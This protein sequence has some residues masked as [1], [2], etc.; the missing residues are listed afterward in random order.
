MH[1]RIYLLVFCIC[2]LCHAFGQEDYT[3]DLA[4]FKAQEATYQQWLEDAGLGEVLKV[5]EVEVEPDLIS[6]YL[7]FNYT[8]LDSIYNAWNQLKASFDQRHDISL[9]QQL[10]YKFT[11]IFDLPEDDG[12]VQLYD[13]YSLDKKIC[14]YWGIYFETGEVITEFEDH[15]GKATKIFQVDTAD[16]SDTKKITAESIQNRLTQS[17]VFDE[18]LRFARQRFEQPVCPDRNP[19]V[20]LRENKHLLRFE[21]DDLCKEVLHD[22]SNHVLCRIATRLRFTCNTIS[23][24]RLNFTITY[25]KINKGFQL[26]CEI[27]GKYAQGILG[28]KPR[29]ADYKNMEEGEFKEYLELYADLFVQDLRKIL[30]RL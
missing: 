3:L 9:E 17:K 24:E 15:C 28:R 6:L 23:R 20:R 12:N 14:Y 4:F 26:T 13:E 11:H 19:L 22:E 30:V 21:V 25:E 16:F 27:D 1:R 8:D 18:I 7:A 29:R 5:Q 10:F 2:W